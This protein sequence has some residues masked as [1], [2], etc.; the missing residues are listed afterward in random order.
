M[1]P[2]SLE[3]MLLVYKS[4][5]SGAVHRPRSAA[6]Q[7]GSG[8]ASSI[9]Q[10][11][12]LARSGSS[13]SL[14]TPTTPSSRRSASVAAARWHHGHAL[15]TYSWYL[16]LTAGSSAGQP[17]TLPNCAAGRTYAPSADCGAS[18]ESIV[19]QQKYHPLLAVLTRSCCEGSHSRRRR[20]P[21]GAH[22]TAA[23]CRGN[24]RGVRPGGA[25]RAWS[26]A[27][28]SGAAIIR[29]AR[30]GRER[31]QKDT[32]TTYYQYHLACGCEDESATIK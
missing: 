32:G 13:T 25:T 30:I 7:S 6:P 16:P 12:R 4:T 24:A 28:S 27:H 26:S 15:P 9:A 18:S 20:P 11:P 14:V 1:S 29:L 3:I 2:D 17:L 21:R 19:L 5:R 23:P 8:S 31:K 10:P 22:S